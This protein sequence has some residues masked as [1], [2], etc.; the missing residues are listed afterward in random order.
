[1]GNP[2]RLDSSRFATLATLNAHFLSSTACLPTFKEERAMHIQPV[3]GLRSVFSLALFFILCCGVA[4]APRAVTA[5]PPEGSSGVRLIDG[6]Q[7]SDAQNGPAAV[8]PPT[9]TK[10][11]EEKPAADDKDTN[12]ETPTPVPEPRQ[13]GAVELEAPSLHGVTPGVT[14]MEE[15]DKAWGAAKEIRKQDDMTMRLYEVAGFPHVEASC[16]DGKVL[17][18]VIRLEKDAPPDFVA[19]RLGMAKIEPVLI[20]NELGELLGQAYPERGVLFLFEP[21]GT[22]TKPSMKVNSIVLEPIAP[23]RS[24]CAGNESRRP[25]GRQPARSR[26]GREASARERPGAVAALPRAGILRRI[27]QGGQR[28]DR[29]DSSGAARDPRYHATRAQ[30]RAQAGMLQ[31]ATEEAKQTIEL[32]KQRPHVQARA[33]CLLGDVAASGPQARLQAGPGLSHAGREIGDAP[34]TGSEHP[35][36]RIAAEEVALDAHMGAARHRL[37]QHATE[38]EKA[39]GVWLDKASDFAEQLIQQRG[40]QF[41]VSLPLERACPAACVGLAASFRR[42]PGSIRRWKTARA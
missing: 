38:K 8:E 12:K 30:A 20:S 34:L 40:T 15:M 31:E 5:A 2:Y 22:V 35:A 21:G 4:I 19:Q 39:V 16:R 13:T 25:S 29:G 14:N 28:R 32:A 1:M 24:C 3:R 10:L 27:R 9:T 41:G 18:I 17:S 36:V 33:F 23:S 37:E 11:L 7:P 26:R 6:G 42:L